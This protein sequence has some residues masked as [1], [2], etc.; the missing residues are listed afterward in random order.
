MVN[1][2]AINYN[3]IYFYSCPQKITFLNVCQLQNLFLNLKHLYPQR[4]VLI[5]PL[6]GIKNYILKNKPLDF[7]ILEIL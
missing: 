7:I 6:E 2:N 5:G 4:K 1:S 3:I